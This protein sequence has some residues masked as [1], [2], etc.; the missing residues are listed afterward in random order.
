MR[1]PIDPKI[2]CVFKALLGAEGNRHLLVHFLNAI[3]GPDLPAPITGVAIL[4][5]YN[6]REHGDDKLSIV[7]IKARDDQG[8][9]AQ[10]EIQLLAFP[11]LPARILYGWAELYRQQLQ[12][13]D[14]YDQLQPAYAIWLLAEDLVRD[15]HDYLH[16]YR[17]RDDQGRGL[18]NHGGIWLLEL[19]KFR[20]DRV[21]SEQQR[22]LKFFKDGERL[23]AAAL[24]D[25]M[26][27]D[28]MRQAMTTSTLLTLCL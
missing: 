28:E 17:L 25:W 23:D 15:D 7:D 5:P 6:E 22:W 18:L 10:I 3:L 4:N 9:L 20:I 11:D 27:T 26:Q 2:D 8:R 16:R 21:V 1:H 14:D 13:G 24:P 12:V 19:N